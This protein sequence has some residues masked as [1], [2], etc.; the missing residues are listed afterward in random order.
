LQHFAL[1]DHRR[2][3]GQNRQHRQFPVL[4]HQLERAAEQNVADQD[5]GLVAPYRVGAG[6]AP[7]QVAFVHHVVV[8]Q[9][10][11][12]DEFDA[13]GELD[14]ALAGIAAQAG[15][16]Q[17]QHRAQAFASGGDNVAG[18]LGNERNVAVH[19]ADNGVV[20]QPKIIADQADQDLQGRR[21]TQLP[22]QIDDNGHRRILS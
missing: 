20:D 21:L 12:M 8:E 2:G 10:G 14:V 17:G 6:V 19:A 1:G 9:G 15:G 16:G 5:A 3:V 18:K 4:H 22:A 7:A 11:G 13:G